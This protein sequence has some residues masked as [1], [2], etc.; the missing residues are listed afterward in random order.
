VARPPSGPLWVHEIKHDGYRLMVR[1][2]GVRFAASRATVMIGMTGYG[3]IVEAGHS[4]MLTRGRGS[5]RPLG[6]DMRPFLS[7]ACILASFSSAAIAGPKEEALAV[8]EEWTKA[9]AASDVDA[10]V[11]LNAPDALFMGTG[12]QTVVT[13]PAAIR[14]YFEGA[15]LTRKPRAA[16]ISSSEVMVLSDTAV[17]IAGLNNSTGVLDGKPFN[18]PGRVTFVIAKRDSDWKIVHFH[19]SAMPQ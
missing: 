18:N 7:V 9:F 13:D 2:D 8:L 16:P 15:L 3:P 14:K 11:K 12:S 1:R 10:I 4:T 5:V 17:V 6:E 19:R